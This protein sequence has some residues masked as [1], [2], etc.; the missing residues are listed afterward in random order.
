MF[1][2]YLKIAW[3]NLI[4]N[5]VYSTINISG[6]AIGLAVCM[7]IVLYVGHEYSYDRFHNKA[8]RIF[9]V[10]SEI[11]MGNDPI[12]MPY[13]GYSDAAASKQNIPAVE[14]F[15][16]FN[17]N[18]EKVIVQNPGSPSLKF[19]ENKFLLAD[20]NFFN[21]FSFQLV[22]GDKD[23]VLQNPFSVVISEKA[24]EKYF[25]NQ[26]PV[27]KTIRYNNEHDF[28]VTGIAENPPS[29]SSIDYDFVASISSMASMEE[30]KDFLTLM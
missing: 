18:F 10:E 22:R 26:N 2:N 5:K 4:R 30:K 14:D 20:G 27:G 16:C 12:I 24:A 13:M 11:K 8:D 29:N 25:G 17:Q 28:V 9:Q 1:K 23:Q 6:L 15:V 3:R 21:F 19:A 7:L